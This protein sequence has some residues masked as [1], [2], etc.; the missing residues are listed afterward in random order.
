LRRLL[1]AGLAA[2]LAIAGCS[3]GSGGPKAVVPEDQADF[4]DVPVTNDMNNVRVKQFTIKNEGAG[5]LKLS[6][7]Q[8]K[9]LEGC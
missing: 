9:V 8:V 4:G 1:L 6:N 2:A 7:L 5:Q 3:S